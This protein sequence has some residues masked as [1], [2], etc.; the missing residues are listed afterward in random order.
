MLSRLLECLTEV[1]YIRLSQ[2]PFQD[3]CSTC[4]FQ[5]AIELLEVYLG[6]VDPPLAK[7]CVLILLLKLYVSAYYHIPEVQ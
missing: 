4:G 1:Q 2:C 3:I 7:L 6:P 5:V